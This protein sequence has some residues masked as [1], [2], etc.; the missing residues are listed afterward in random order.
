MENS[1][2]LS[3][4]IDLNNNRLTNPNPYPNPNP[5]PKRNCNYNPNPLI[6]Y[7]TPMVVY[8]P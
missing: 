4:N 7:T 1:S 5:N 8:L 2:F 6:D 3:N